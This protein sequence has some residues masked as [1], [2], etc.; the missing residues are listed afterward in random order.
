MHRSDLIFGQ[1]KPPPLSR[2]RVDGRRDG[3][4]LALDQAASNAV[5][6]SNAWSLPLLAGLPFRLIWR[7]T[8]SLGRAHENSLLTA[9]LAGH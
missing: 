3:V 2:K 6:L 1:D 9:N 8:P 7:R 4:P 5:T